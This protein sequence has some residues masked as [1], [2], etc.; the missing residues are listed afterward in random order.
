MK[1]KYFKHADMAMCVWLNLHKNETTGFIYLKVRINHHWDS[2]PFLI[3]DTG[4]LIKL[5]IINTAVIGRQ[6][7][8]HPVLLL[9]LGFLCQKLILQGKAPFHFLLF[10]S[11]LR[12]RRFSFCQLF[13]IFTPGA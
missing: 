10:Y 6:C 8:D 12:L 11:C 13:R 7:P 9:R 3:A 1:R 4:P 2:F 5:Q